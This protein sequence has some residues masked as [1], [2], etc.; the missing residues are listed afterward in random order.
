VRI[1]KQCDE[2]K[3]SKLFW[4]L[5]RDVISR[6]TNERSEGCVVR[7]SGGK[8]QT[9]YVVRGSQRERGRGGRWKGQVPRDTVQYQVDSSGGDRPT[10]GGVCAG[11]S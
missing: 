2:V 8:V 10:I 9:D 3:T 1:S 4:D 5:H 6:L 7:G 11:W